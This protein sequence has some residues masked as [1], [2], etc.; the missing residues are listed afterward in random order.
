MPNSKG[1]TLVQIL[2]GLAAAAIVATAIVYTTQRLGSNPAPANQA[3]VTNSAANTN[4][5]TNENTVADINSPELTLEEDARVGPPAGWKTY[6]DSA[7][8]ISVQYPPT[9][10]TDGST[11]GNIHLN[12]PTDGTKQEDT[13]TNSVFI[14]SLK[15]EGEGDLLSNTK[16]VIVN[17]ITATQG[18]EGQIPFET[19]TLILQGNNAVRVSWG[20]DSSL[21]DVKSQILSTITFTDQTAATK[22]WKTYRNVKHGL[23]FRYPKDWFV[24]SQQTD[25]WILT[26][27]DTSKQTGRG[28]LDDGMMKMDFSISTAPAGRTPAK[29]VPCP[30]TEG[31]TLVSCEAVTILDR[32]YTERI[33]DS[34]IEGRSRDVT[35]A[36]ITNGKLYQVNA[37]ASAGNAQDDALVTYD[38]IFSTFS[39]T[40]V[41]ATK[42]W[43]TYT[44]KTDGYSI[45][46]P[47]EWTLDTSGSIAYINYPSSSQPYGADG[48]IYVSFRAEKNVTKSLAEWFTAGEELTQEK[49][50][51][52]LDKVKAGTGD[53]GPGYADQ[54]FS[55]TTTTVGGQPAI[56]QYVKATRPTYIEGPATTSKAYYVKVGT[57]V[58]WIL[59]SAPTG[60]K[61]EALLQTFDAMI[62][63]FTF[64]N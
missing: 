3:L 27:F 2:L 54:E 45:R 42:D 46:Y 11:P 4:A 48:D 24:S 55:N 25:S 20:E 52:T 62:G 60:T 40:E 9:W 57:T 50:Q 47:K 49:I 21:L 61:S 29:A 1:F 31:E 33:V 15:S 10:T 26:S 16:K 39:I 64:T 51:A 41:A 6:T 22:D 13:A 43:K 36:T 59:G 34:I 44:N 37:L 38:R 56:Y 7:L 35:V 23:S 5:A 8:H 58:Y 14:G 53:V 28:G 17:G 19:V 63:T 32:T 30:A 18:R 12:P